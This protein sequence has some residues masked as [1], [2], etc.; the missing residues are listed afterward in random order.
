[1]AEQKLNL[2][3]KLQKARVEL[4]EMN[5]KKSGQNKFAGFS[6]YELSDFLPA[7]NIICNNVNLRGR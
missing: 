1:M 6:Y 2:F 4:Q 7:I 5:L 3:Q